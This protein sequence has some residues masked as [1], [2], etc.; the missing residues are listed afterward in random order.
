MVKLLVTLIP[1]C[2]NLYIPCVSARFLTNV[3]S[4]VVMNK[5]VPWEITF[6][7]CSWSIYSIIIEVK[8][9]LNIES[10]I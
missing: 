7:D 5:T 6:S 3:H 9:G 8:N 2:V 10:P 4:K 1:N